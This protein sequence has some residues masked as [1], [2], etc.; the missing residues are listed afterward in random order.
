MYLSKKAS[1]EGV[2]FEGEAVVLGPTAIG[3]GSVIGLYSILGYPILPKVRGSRASLES[4]DELSEGVRVG[5][6]CFIRSN[7]VIYE[8]VVIGNRVQTGHFILIREDSQVGDNTVIGTNSLIDGRVR[9]GS[10][11]SIQSGVYIPPMSVIGDRVF[12]APFVVLTNDKY[13]PSKR[14]LGVTVEDDAVI[15][16]NS[17]LV[18]GVRI[19]EGAVVAAGAVVTRDVP[20][21]KVVMGAPARVVGTRDEYE[22]K[23]RDYEIQTSSIPP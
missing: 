3:R 19:G 20:P 4:Y 1:V 16:A 15:G 12:L 14:L 21:G 8:K 17:V 2:L 10:R 11:V 9:I 13:P 7:S 5:E 22:S 6:D 18:S 23:K